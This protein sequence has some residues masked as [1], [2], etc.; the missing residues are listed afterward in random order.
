MNTPNLPERLRDHEAPHIRHPELQILDA[1][2]RIEELLQKLVERFDLDDTKVDGDITDIVK[3]IAPTETP[4][5]KTVAASAK[6][7]NPRQL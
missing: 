3:N 1:L 6:R 7:K 2:L 4:F 5:T